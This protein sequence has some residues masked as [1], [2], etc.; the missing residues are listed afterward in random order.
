MSV[1]WQAGP[2]PVGWLTLGTQI[3]LGPFALRLI[4]DGRGNRDDLS[5]FPLECNPLLPD[6]D[7][8]GPLPHV[9]LEWLG[10]PADTPPRRV[11]RLI[12]VVGRDALCQLR[13]SDETV[14]RV[15]CSLVLTQRRFWVIDLFGRGGTRL[16]GERI[17]RCTPG[18]GDILQVGSFQCRVH[19]GQPTAASELGSSITAA[20]PR[21]ARDSRKTMVAVQ[22]HRR[23]AQRTALPGF[24]AAFRVDS[25]AATLL[26]APLSER[27]L[28]CPAEVER[29]LSLL[30]RRVSQSPPTNVVVD[31]GRVKSAGSDLIGL[32][33]RI[34]KH[35]CDAGGKAALCNAAGRLRQTLDAM[36][37]LDL[38][39][40]FESTLAALRFVEG[41]ANRAARAAE[42]VLVESDTDPAIEVA[43]HSIDLTWKGSLFEVSHRA[44]T[45]IIAP[46]VQGRAFEYVKLHAE[47]T[48]LRRKLEHPEIEKVVLDLGHVDSH[49]AEVIGVIVDLAHTITVR[50]GTAVL[51]NVAQKLHHTLHRMH[52]DELWPIVESR[53]DALR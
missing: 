7:D 13:L 11:K 27:L 1:E 21:R 51:C 12:T 45:L 14:S 18:C 49:G 28:Q 9:S 53:E 26:V 15:H 17:E 5:S 34:C 6:P 29:E 33:V 44:S 8:F 19:I 50:G 25:A 23:S 46:Q 4:D 3:K 37:L 16:N 24:G 10:G 2:R 39:P 41:E 48:A 47:S 31:L 20:R 43:T 36:H 22:P 52:L 30:E 42:H 35:S 32:V 38:W 40:H